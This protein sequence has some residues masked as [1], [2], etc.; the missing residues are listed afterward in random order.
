M[1]TAFEM[2]LWVLFNSSV[3]FIQI[4]EQNVDPID[5]LTQLKFK[6]A[7]QM[8]PLQ[9]SQHFKV[10]FIIIR[11]VLW[12]TFSSFMDFL[13]NSHLISWSLLTFFK[14]FVVISVL[15]EELSY[16]NDSGKRLQKINK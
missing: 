12:S 9:P 16:L 13:L 5:N 15:N 2:Y 4:Y 10:I 14:Y 6:S 1:G 8:N 3:R 7:H 11:I